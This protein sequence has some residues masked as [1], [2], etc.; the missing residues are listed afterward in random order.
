MI[1]VR[2]D[3]D[4]NAYEADRKTREITELVRKNEELRDALEHLERCKPRRVEENAL[5]EFVELRKLVP[6]PARP[7][8]AVPS[9]TVWCRWSSLGD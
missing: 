8:Y 6:K 9:A 7:R 3:I 1:S 4:D 2:R 5:R